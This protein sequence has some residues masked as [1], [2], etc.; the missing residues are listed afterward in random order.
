M[1]W[2]FPGDAKVRILG[3]PLQ[4]AWVWSL[5][6][7]LRFTRCLPW[8][9]KK[10]KNLMCCPSKKHLCLET[11]NL[12]PGMQNQVGYTLKASSRADVLWFLLFWV[13]K[14][15]VI[16]ET[17]TCGDESFHV[18]TQPHPITWP[19]VKI[20]D[21][22]IKFDASRYKQY[23]SWDVKAASTLGS[24]NKAETLS[25][26]EDHGNYKGKIKFSWY[27]Y[28]IFASVQGSLT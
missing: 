12:L 27:G 6:E 28:W 20:W 10:K 18:N 21:Q 5:V 3:F 17:L 11:S 19:T 23:I 14:C 13:C 7:E 24:K 15:C 1:C 16:C 4:G 9:K 22:P 25:Q 2:H 26:L 8:P